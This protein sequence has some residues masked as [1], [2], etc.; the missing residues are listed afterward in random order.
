MVCCGYEITVET[1]FSDS[2]PGICYT[3][4]YMETIITYTDGVARGN[5]GPSGVGV[6]ITTKDGEVVKEAKEAIGNAT[7]NFAEYYGV[8]LGLQTL[9]TLYSKKTKE[10]QFEIRLDSEFVKNQ[11]SGESQ[12]K[13]PG[14]VPMFIEIHNMQVEHFPNIVFTL[15]PR[16][17]NK[18]AD[19]LANEVIDGK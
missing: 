6:Y 7:D 15:V 11:L 16:A 4:L 17:Q 3:L 9:K 5:P 10:M 13:D 14:L 8:M 1:T 2:C 19:R 18:E 12:I